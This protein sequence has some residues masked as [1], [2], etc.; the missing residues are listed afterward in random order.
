MAELFQYSADITAGSLLLT[1]T[2]VVAGLLLDGHNFKEI[3]KLV[4]T[5]NVLQKRSTASATRMY[6]LI[7][8]RL[9]LFDSELWS[10]IYY[11]DSE[12]S[13]MAALAA[14]IKNSRILGDFMLFV[15]KEKYQ[16][17]EKAMPKNAWDRFIDDCKMKNPDMPSWTDKTAKKIGDCVYR[18][19]AE[20]GYLSSTKEALLQKVYIPAEI[21]KYLTAHN[22]N[23]VL[24]CMEVSL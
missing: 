4:E 14:T 6:S 20:T 5:Q 3:G 16:L 10:M 7:K 12:T 21:K 2:K 11:G 1:E 24:Q 22:D 8:H 19:L 23:Y 15:L 13:R 17:F 9:E 18:I